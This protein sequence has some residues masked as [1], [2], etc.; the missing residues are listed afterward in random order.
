MSSAGS[1]C[2]LEFQEFATRRLQDPSK[3]MGSGATGHTL[4]FMLMIRAT[5]SKT[6]FVTRAR[7]WKYF[8]I[9]ELP[10]TRRSAKFCRH[11]TRC[12]SRSPC[13]LRSTPWTDMQCTTSACTTCVFPAINV[14][15]CVAVIAAGFKSCL[16]ERAGTPLSTGQSCTANLYSP[17][18]NDACHWRHSF[19]FTV[20]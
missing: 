4:Q 16:P 3:R 13:V 18:R 11:Q 20:S 19:A 8:D 5:N 1:T 12:D 7:R 9:C 10:S 2:I 14:S 6:K 15:L 17:P